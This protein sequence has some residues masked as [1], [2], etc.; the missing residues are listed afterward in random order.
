MTQHNHLLHLHLHGKKRLTGFDKIMLTAAF[1]YPVTG[2][3]Q[4]VQVFNGNTEG[5]SVLSWAGFT[6]FVSIFLVYSIIHRIKP[7]IITYAMWLV[8]DVLV[9][10]GVFLHR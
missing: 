5:V 10:V 3:P 1:I 6:F 9:V 7:M 8:V 4:I 2:I